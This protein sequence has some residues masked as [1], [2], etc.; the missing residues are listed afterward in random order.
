MSDTT[1]AS[2]LVWCLQAHHCRRRRALFPSARYLLLGLLPGATVAGVGLVCY[3]L[4][5]TE[6]NYKYT[7]SAWHCCIAISILFLLPPRRAQT[8]SYSLG[9]GGGGSGSSTGKL[10]RV[11]A[12][13]S[14]QTVNTSSA[15][16]E[17]GVA[18]GHR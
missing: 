2:R 12:G 8:E 15:D 3:A 17:R 9:G 7:H 11:S 14:Q 1:I 18:D 13:G 10:L 5:E 4:L 6:Q 16:S